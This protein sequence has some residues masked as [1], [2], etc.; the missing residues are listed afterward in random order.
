MANWSSI[1][2]AAGGG[3]PLGLFLILW[4]LRFLECVVCWCAGSAGS[5]GGYLC[6]RG[7]EVGSGGDVEVVQTVLM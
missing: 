4:G 2:V 7:S 6:C 3:F 1:F 5:V